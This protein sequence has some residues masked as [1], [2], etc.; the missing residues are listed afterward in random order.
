LRQR[1]EILQRQDIDRQAAL[2]ARIEAQSAR[3]RRDTDL[4]L[5][6]LRTPVPAPDEGLALRPALPLPQAPPS[7]EYDRISA[8]MEARLAA[9]TLRLNAMRLAARP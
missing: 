7:S 1:D 6:D 4:T 9:S 3:A 2:F 8:A 5:R